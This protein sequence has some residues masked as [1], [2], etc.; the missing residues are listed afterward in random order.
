MPAN[1]I[2][3]SIN[4]TQ[5]SYYS[6]RDSHGSSCTLYSVDQK[7]VAKK[8]FHA[9]VREVAGPAALLIREHLYAH[10][11]WGGSMPAVFDEKI[12][13]N[14]N[15]TDFNRLLHTERKF[16]RGPQD[17]T[18]DGVAVSA[19]QFREGLDKALKGSFNLLYEGLVTMH[20]SYDR[21]KVTPDEG[22]TPSP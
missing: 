22:S 21:K 4:E 10:H 13:V 5:F 6:A 16:G 14:I 3:F 15:G 17:H 1:T 12:E 2:N 11:L 18:I 7:I 9:K 19:Q 8:D 20:P